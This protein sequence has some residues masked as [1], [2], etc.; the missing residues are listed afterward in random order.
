MGG[1]V[2]ERRLR[3][4]Q[5]QATIIEYFIKAPWV[6][7]TFITVDKSVS[8]TGSRVDSKSNNNSSNYYKQM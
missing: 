6:E 5:Y 3:F 7:Y 2:Y 4:V 1:S 8:S